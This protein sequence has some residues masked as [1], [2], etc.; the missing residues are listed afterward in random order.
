MVCE[1]MCSGM[2]HYAVMCG[3]GHW[4]E[5]YH[6]SL[7]SEEPLAQWQCHITEDLNPQKNHRANIISFT[8]T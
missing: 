8:E 3:S 7:K 6:S 1:F 4:K 5:L 2:Q